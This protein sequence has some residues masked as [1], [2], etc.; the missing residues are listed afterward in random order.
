MIGEICPS[1][2]GVIGRDCWN[3]GECAIISA[4]MARS[5]PLAEGGVPEGQQDS[6]SQ[7]H[8]PATGSA[9]DPADEAQMALCHLDFI[10]NL[11]GVH[12]HRAASIRRALERL[13]SFSDATLCIA[14]QG[15]L[16]GGDR[17][18]ADASGGFIHA[19]CCGPERESYTGAGGDPLGPD[20]P[21]PEPSIWE[22]EW[23]NEPSR[24]ERSETS[25]GEG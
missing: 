5:T 20:E 17:Y 25:G 6:S 16:R 3:P 13:A 23:K 10:T 12:P 4:D 18:Y 22:D 1:C 9:L 14:C 21:I 24:P 7:D 19:D 2:N 11:P 15:R 8:A